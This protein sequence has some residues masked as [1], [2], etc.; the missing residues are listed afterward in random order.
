MSV[1]TTVR[2]RIG[3]HEPTR[4]KVKWD[5][6]TYVSHCKHCGEAIERH[7]HKDWRKIGEAEVAWR[8]KAKVQEMTFGSD[9]K[10]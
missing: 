10:A 3:R 9:Q 4:R 6:K 5:G 2:C 7:G 8:L 1:L